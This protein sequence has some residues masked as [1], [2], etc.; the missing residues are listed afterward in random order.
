MGDTTN[1]HAV[2]IYIILPLLY[3]YN[4]SILVIVTRYLLNID[5]EWW[6]LKIIDKNYFIL[7]AKPITVGRK[8]Y[9]FCKSITIH[10]EED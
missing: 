2:I 5:H 10:Y 6:K 7:F 8:E 4:I 1:G 9:S 3:R